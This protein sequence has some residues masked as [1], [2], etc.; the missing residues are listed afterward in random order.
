MSRDSKRMVINKKKNEEETGIL[1]CI[2][3]ACLFGRSFVCVCQLQTIIITI[4]ARSR[5]IL[6]RSSSSSLSWSS[7]T[8]QLSSI[9]SRGNYSGF[10]LWTYLI[11]LSLN[12]SHAQQSRIFIYITWL[13][14]LFG[15]LF[16]FF[17]F[18]N[19]LHTILTFTEAY[20]HNTLAISKF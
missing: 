18:T 14:F 15:L 19:D 12:R 6:L 10:P 5:H 2:S 8:F 16:L 7:F 11:S 4:D 3:V 20:T 9:N 1:C 17:L 13:V